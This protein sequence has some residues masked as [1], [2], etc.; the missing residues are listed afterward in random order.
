MMNFLNELSK[1][2]YIIFSLLAIVVIIASLILV[3]ILTKKNKPV[4]DKYEE[5]KV[6]KN[7]LPVVKIALATNIEDIEK[8]IKKNSEQEKLRMREQD[9]KNQTSIESVLKAMEQDLEKEKFAKIDAYEEEQ[10]KEAVITYQELRDKMMAKKAQ[11]EE[12]EITKYNNAFFDILDTNENEIEEEIIAPTEYNYS[13]NIILPEYEETQVEPVLIENTYNII[14]EKLETCNIDNSYNGT[15]EP[16]EFISPIFGKQT[17]TTYFN[18]EIKEEL[19]EDKRKD[20]AL[21]SDT[22]DFLNNLKEFRNS[23]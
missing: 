17:E 20:I 6:V 13:S 22:D 10:E 15:L 3:L 8:K 9:M 12:I 5:K 2:D 11:E 19:I 23:L 14:E 4:I 18:S 1:T 21:T 7:K 16:K